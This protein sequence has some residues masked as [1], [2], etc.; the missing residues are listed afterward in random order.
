[1]TD[2]VQVGLILGVFVFWIY[3]NRRHP[4]LLSW[5]LVVLVFV[6][7]FLASSRYEQ[8]NTYDIH[9]QLP[10]ETIQRPESIS[11]SGND[12]D[13]DLTYL[14]LVDWRPIRTF[15]N[16]AMQV[17]RPTFRS[18]GPFVNPHTIFY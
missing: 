5:G 10:R 13:P 17:R 1:M 12:R 8:G 18:F 16:F 14:S 9:S 3:R 15:E 11:Y 7:L 4:N 2:V 6:D